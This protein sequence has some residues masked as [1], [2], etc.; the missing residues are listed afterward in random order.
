[1]YGQ[2]CTDESSFADSVIFEDPAAKC[3]GVAEVQ[4]AFRALAK[5]QPKT[6]DWELGCVDEDR[7][8]VEVNVWQRYQIGFGKGTDL[9]SKILVSYDE[10]GQITKMVDLWR[11]LPLLSSAPFTW[12]RRLNGLLSFQLT[13][14]MK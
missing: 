2:C 8:T 4:E 3:L 6:L 14:F 9:Y 12:S 1:M 10:E 11:G 5:L 7:K 13:P